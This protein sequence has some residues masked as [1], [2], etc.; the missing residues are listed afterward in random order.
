MSHTQLIN[1][2]RTLLNDA[3]ISPSMRLLLSKQL[4]SE[5]DTNDSGR[6]TN[7][8]LLKKEQNN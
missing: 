4:L 5:K 3:S 7:K 1:R 6:K 8:S 2:L